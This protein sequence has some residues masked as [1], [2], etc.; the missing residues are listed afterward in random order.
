MNGLASKAQVVAEVNVMRFVRSPVSGGAVQSFNKGRWR[1]AAAHNSWHPRV[2]RCCRQ[3]QLVRIATTLAQHRWYSFIYSP[4]KLSGLPHSWG[5]G[6]LTEVAIS[7]TQ[8]AASHRPHRQQVWR[9]PEL[10]VSGEQTADAWQPNPLLP[11][12]HRPLGTW[13]SLEDKLIN[14]VKAFFFVLLVS[15]PPT[16]VVIMGSSSDNP[17][18]GTVTFF[19]KI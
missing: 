10:R 9:L 2:R 12:L 4:Y 1:P 16:F 18:V 3:Q 7:V 19:L 6:F 17:A 8:L 14:T 13:V 11:V 15:P 5:V